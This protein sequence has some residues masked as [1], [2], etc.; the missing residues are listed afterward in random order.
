MSFQTLINYIIIAVL[1]YNLQEYFGLC[2][3]IVYICMV[4]FYCLYL[5]T[6]ERK[7]KRQADELR[8]KRIDILVG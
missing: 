2:I 4:E 7:A 5:D 6:K 3:A 8:R 1:A